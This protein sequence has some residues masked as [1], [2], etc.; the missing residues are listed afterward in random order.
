MRSLTA[1]RRLWRSH[2]SSSPAL[3]STPLR[4]LATERHP[5]L[6]GV[7]RWPSQRMPT[8]GS[9]SVPLRNGLPPFVLFN[10]L[11]TSSKDRTPR[12]PL[13]PYWDF[14]TNYSVEPGHTTERINTV[15]LYSPHFCCSFSSYT[16]RDLPGM[17]NRISAQPRPV[18]PLFSAVLGGCL[19]EILGNAEYP[20]HGRYTHGREV[21]S[22][23]EPTGVMTCR[24]VQVGTCEVHFPEPCA[25]LLCNGHG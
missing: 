5:S 17:H 20:T 24:M 14:T 8:S 3:S 19:I 4:P 2:P 11:C 12:M 1:G 16:R 7:W 25:M 18:M 21:H 6:S 23:H 9:L 15:D 13:M 22:S 10:S